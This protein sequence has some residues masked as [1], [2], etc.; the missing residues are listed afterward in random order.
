MTI[1]T[2]ELEA[3][4]MTDSELSAAQANT[5]AGVLEDAQLVKRL[6]TN[7]SVDRLAAALRLKLRYLEAIRDE[8]RFRRSFAR[9]K[10]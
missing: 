7:A 9:S 4:T 1:P 5:R 8:C 2:S 6:P 3:L 10:R